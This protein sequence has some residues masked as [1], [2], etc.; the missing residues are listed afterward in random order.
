MKKKKGN[1]LPNILLR[2]KFGNFM[3]ILTKKMI[4]IFSSSEDH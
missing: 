2:K 4:L 1:Q 3:A